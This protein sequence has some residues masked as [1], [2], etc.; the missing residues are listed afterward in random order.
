M[1]F[2]FKPRF[3]AATATTT[4]TGSIF[5]FVLMY[6]LMVLPVNLF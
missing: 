5:G 1:A 6:H 4:A 2:S 3:G